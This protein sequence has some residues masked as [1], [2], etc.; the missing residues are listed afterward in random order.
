[1]EVDL[2]PEDLIAPENPH[3]QMPLPPPAPA[4]EDPTPT[5]PTEHL[6][7]ALGEE[8]DNEEVPREHVLM[9]NLEGDSS[10]E[11]VE[12]QVAKVSPRLNLRMFGI[13][14]RI[15]IVLKALKPR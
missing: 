12:A 9:N 3:F 10:D 11:E 7:G 1:M 4:S 2:D 14:L 13:S 5:P 8:S 6:N 15:L